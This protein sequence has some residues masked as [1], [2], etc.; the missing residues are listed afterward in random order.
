MADESYSR[1]RLRLAIPSV[2]ESV[3][4]SLIVVRALSARVEELSAQRMAAE[5]WYV[6]VRVVPGGAGDAAYRLGRFEFVWNERR[7][8]MLDSP[9]W[10]PQALEAAPAPSVIRAEDS[11]PM[12][13]DETLA[14]LV[15]HVSAAGLN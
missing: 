2:Q 7:G 1:H 8:W 10:G 4:A 3:G 6:F 13:A 11:I 5:V 9:A 12:A 14:R 15:G